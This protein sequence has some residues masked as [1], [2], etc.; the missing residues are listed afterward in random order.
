[1]SSGT[2]SSHS[3]ANSSPVT[4]RGTCAVHTVPAQLRSVHS[5]VDGA[6]GGASGRA[7]SS[8]AHT[9]S[10]SPTGSGSSASTPA[11]SSPRPAP[12]STKASSS[13]RP[14]ASSTSSSSRATARANSGEACTE[15]RKCPA[16]PSGLR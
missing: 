4:P 13:G 1:M 3:L 7:A 16:G 12:T 2:L 14:S 5:P 11:T 6:A 9:R 15:V 10:R 8:T